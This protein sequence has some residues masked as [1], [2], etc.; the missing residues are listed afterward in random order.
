MSSNTACISTDST[1]VNSH[2]WCLTAY[3]LSGFMPEYTELP[4]CD[5]GQEIRKCKY[6]VIAFQWNHQVSYLGNYFSGNFTLLLLT[7]Y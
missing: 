7:W 2:N 3:I 4:A 6:F 5:R 1:G